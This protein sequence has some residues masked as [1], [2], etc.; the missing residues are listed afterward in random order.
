L[1]TCVCSVSGQ[2]L[3]F[4]AVPTELGLSQNFISD[5]AEDTTGFIWVATPSGLN[6]FDG[7]SYKV[8]KNEPDDSLSLGDDNTLKLLIDKRGALWIGHAKGLQVYDIQTNH[9]ISIPLGRETSVR[10]L[11]NGNSND[12]WVVDGNRTIHHI[13]YHAGFECE[14]R[15]YSNPLP[16][17][18]KKDDIVR[19]IAID[20]SGR[21]WINAGVF[22]ALVSFETDRPSV[23]FVDWDRFKEKKGISLTEALRPENFLGDK[24]AQGMFSDAD[25]RIFIYDEGLLTLIVKDEVR[26]IDIRSLENSDQVNYASWRYKG[27][28]DRSGVLWLHTS[29]AE[30]SVAIDIENE[31]ILNGNKAIFGNITAGIMRIIQAK[32]GV[33]WLGTNGNGIYRAIPDKEIFNSPPVSEKVATRT[34]YP[35]YKDEEGHVW[36]CNLTDVEVIPNGMR[37][38]QQLSFSLAGYSFVRKNP[39]SFN[40]SAKFITGDGEGGMWLG[41][42]DGLHRIRKE[43]IKLIQHE[44]FRIE[45][46]SR[47]GDNDFL[48]GVYDLITD[49]DGQ[50]WIATAGEFGKF[51]PESGVFEGFA[52]DTEFN[53][54]DDNRITNRV[55]QADATT[56]WIGTINGLVRFDTTTES[57]EIYHHEPKNINSLATNSVKCIASD[58][59]D[60]DVIWIGTYGEGLDRY[61]ARTN[62]FQHFSLEEGLPDETV[63]GILS[64]GDNELWLSTNKGLCSF[65]IKNQTFQ[66]Y[67]ADD[68]LQDNEFNTR[69][70]SKASDGELLF[71]GIYG[72]NRFY[73]DRLFESDFNP[74]TSITAVKINNE[75]VQFDPDSE[76]L[77][78]PIESAQEISLTPDVK[79]VS[80][81]IAGMDLTFPE[82]T[83]YRYKLEN[84]DDR[85]NDIGNERTITFT[86][87]P[88]GDYTL[89]VKSTNRSGIWSQNIRKLKVR[90]LAPWWQTWWAYALYAV[91][92]LTSIIVL[93]RFQL[94]RTNEKREAQRLLELDSVKS[95]LFTNITHEFRTPITVISGMASMIEG[96]EEYTQTIRKNA[97]NLLQ[98]VNQILDLS[99]LEANKLEIKYKHGNLVEYMH[100]LTESLNGT[101]IQQDKQL[102]F[103]SDQE[104]INMDYD[105]SKIRHILYNLL[106]NALK[107]TTS[108]DRIEV[109]LSKT[110]DNQLSVEVRDTGIGISSEKLPHIFNRFYQA[111]D[112]STRAAE[113]TG[114]GLS[115]CYE[116][117]KLLDGQMEVES[118]EGMG[119][120]FRFSLP[121]YSEYAQGEYEP[122]SQTIP[123]A[124]DRQI[125]NSSSEKETAEKPLLLLIEDNYEIV[126]FIELLLDESYTIVHAENGAIGI[127]AAISKIPDIIISDVMMPMKN[128][129]EVTE[130]LKNDM[131]TSHI[132]IILLTAKSTQADR[133]VGLEKGADAYLH[134]PFDKG[135]LQIRL[136]KLIELR[137]LLISKFKS[138]E[139]SDE[140]GD[141]LENRF[142]YEVK[143]A[144]LE[145]LDNSE[146]K[147]EDLENAVKLS[148]MQLYRKL[149]ALTGMSPTL[150]VRDLR[151]A[152]ASKLIR[153]GEL[154]VSE[155]A[156]EVGFS[157]PSYFTRAFKEKYD[158]VP[159]QYK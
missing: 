132:P 79:M 103:Q 92:T 145:N 26:S 153:K 9:F 95:R 39:N 8:F 78:Q 41:N 61:D 104:E 13:I 46:K 90:A 128:G 107:F 66:T 14:V 40:F 111:D 152:E 91:I 156:Y 144:V 93:Y 11:V 158:M 121:I 155:V 117:V 94:K 18:N 84:F 73:P 86:N 30:A 81:S 123:E 82:K 142:L 146:F 116:L 129:Y 63:Y 135:E 51:Y 125:P 105:E 31:K 120:T 75:V 122:F 68:G 102:V 23:Q 96:Q 34:A 70:F 62:E 137:S 48:L 45:Q 157:D 150:V 118:E 4:E 74:S 21:L 149:K 16:N 28:V 77:S 139:E 12:V 55:I 59:S 83:T 65:D 35:I 42:Y 140:K 136:R 130:H 49:S 5:V 147:V 53:T 115:L 47:N 32:N 151:L 6:R 101:A 113:G 108:G 2:N 67:N 3:K 24:L 148:K 106:S 71:G 98:M 38:P 109:S 88:Y 7:Y 89:L 44:F 57:F 80:F 36:F 54:Y 97:D 60:P 112:S 22:M 20:S 133:N 138:L 110:E 114:I 10:H 76:I 37:A 19:S 29:S 124:V 85:W 99:K 56:F 126:R 100:Y 69:S 15:S 33:F 141:E 131:R 154:T 119:S 17:N 25:G 127:E 64:N 159:S 87:L 72:V 43:G 1:L 50:I 58:P 143:Q 52:F 27:L 134:K